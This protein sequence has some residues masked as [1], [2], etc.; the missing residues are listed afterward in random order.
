[1]SRTSRANFCVSLS[2]AR[3][4]SRSPF[5]SWKRSNARSVATSVSVACFF[6][7]RASASV[8][9][10]VAPP[11]AE[12]IAV[13]ISGPSTMAKTSVKMLCSSRA[14]LFFSTSASESLYDSSI[15]F[16]CCASASPA[17]SRAFA[18][19]STRDCDW[20]DW[21]LE[22]PLMLMGMS[23]LVRTSSNGRAIA[24]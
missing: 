7:S 2:S 12:P 13:P 18:S 3:A 15:F 19:L 4:C 16:A 8:S 22:I 5:L 1:M 23:P 6:S 10:F 24:G 14:A 20:N 17:W 21:S 9:S 11:I